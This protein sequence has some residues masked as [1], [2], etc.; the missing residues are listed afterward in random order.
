[1]ED[2]KINRIGT[3]GSSCNSVYFHVL[4]DFQLVST[5]FSAY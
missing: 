2:M 1:M 5:V 4:Y 3:Y